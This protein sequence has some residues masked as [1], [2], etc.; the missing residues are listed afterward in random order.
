MRV[1]ESAAAVGH[2]VGFSDDD[3]R[4][5]RYYGGEI[6][7]PVFSAVVGGALRLMGVAPDAELEGAA[8]PLTGV[9]TVVS[10]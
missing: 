3:P 7:A 10:R 5:G 6:A 9:A 4:D 2:A 8:D 1:N